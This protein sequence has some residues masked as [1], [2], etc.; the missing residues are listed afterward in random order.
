MSFYSL[1]GCL[2]GRTA[3]L[4]EVERRWEEKKAAL[5]SELER[6]EKLLASAYDR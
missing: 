4:E 3:L 1:H 5:G 6:V 2:T